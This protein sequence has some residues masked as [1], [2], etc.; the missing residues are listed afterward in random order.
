MQGAPAFARQAIQASY[1]W[2]A[3]DAPKFAPS[4]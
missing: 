1:G 2:L 3:R 4:L